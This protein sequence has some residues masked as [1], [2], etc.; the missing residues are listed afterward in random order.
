MS[1]ARSGSEPI[2][3]SLMINPLGGSSFSAL[4]KNFSRNTGDSIYLEYRSTSF[5][6]LR[7]CGLKSCIFQNPLWSDPTVGP[8]ARPRIRAFRTQ[9]RSNLLNLFPPP[10]RAY[11]PQPQTSSLLGRY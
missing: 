8:I 10:S 5:V 9:P 3:G 7:F 11:A 4:F 6:Y 2:I 1:M